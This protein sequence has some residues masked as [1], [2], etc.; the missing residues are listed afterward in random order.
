MNKL[1]SLVFLTLLLATPA[2]A[3]NSTSTLPTGTF[4]LDTA[5]FD[6]T[7]TVRFDD[8]RT[9]RPLLDGIA[10]YE[11]GGGLQGTI[12]AN[13]YVKYQLFVPQLMYGVTD[14]LTVVLA[15]PTVVHTTIQPR[16]GWVPGDYQN[17]LGRPYT[18]SDFWDWAKS[19]GQGKPGDFS[20]N[21]WVPAD[22]VLGLRY[23][24][25][26][27]KPF[28]NNGLRAAVSAQIA[29]PTGQNADPENLVAAGTT[30][31][32]LNNYGDAEVHF[33]LEKPFKWDDLTRLN[34][35]IDVHYAAFL[36]H[37]YT[38]ATGSREPLLM[39]FAPYIGPSYTIDPGD[40]FGGTLLVEGM[41]FVGPTWSTWMNQHDPA[42]SAL[43][44]ALL[45][46]TAS[47]KYAHVNQST[48]KSD[49]AMWDWD[50][51]K[52][53]LPGDK[54]TVKLAADVSL[55][56]MGLPLQLYFA[57]LTQELIPGKNTRATDV[58][59]GGAR[60]LMKFW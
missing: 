27:F 57:Y 26:R 24:L 53:W 20:G 48:W 3:G 47:L 14:D 38:S 7:T 44:P 9:P 59:M 58:L 15:M 60:L 35:G 19:M 56:R 54:N 39:T 55:M 51:N 11:P 18:E 17:N 6:T 36:K 40:Q 28:E 2:W 5:Y 4:V 12:T 34:F 8:S 45:T 29:I 33:A 30:V 32:D 10:R 25:S 21:S 43:W 52:V 13:P 42:K 23:N 41:P 46:L 49:S 37:T 31:W 1:H 16:L 50:H 22:M